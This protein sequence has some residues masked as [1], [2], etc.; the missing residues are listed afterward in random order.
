ALRTRS[1]SQADLVRKAIGKKKRDIMAAEHPKFIAGC[2]KQGLTEA[3]AE[4]LWALIQPFADYSFNKAHAACYA[5]IAVQTAYLKAHF[6]AAFM[7]ALMTSDYG[8]IDRIA[9]EVAE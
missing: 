8:N 6:P 2:L 3:G 1:A 7:A 9:I 4:E 5:M